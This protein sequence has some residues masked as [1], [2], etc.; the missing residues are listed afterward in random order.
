MTTKEKN[1][2]RKMKKEDNMKKGT[3]KEMKMHGKSSDMKNK[4]SAKKK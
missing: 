3:K 1:M 2:E 4:K